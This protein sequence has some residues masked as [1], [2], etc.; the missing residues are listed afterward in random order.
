MVLNPGTEKAEGLNCSLMH[1]GGLD[2]GIVSRLYCL[3]QH[4]NSLMHL[5][6]C[7]ELH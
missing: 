3:E 4:E 5:E 1:T 7:I 6:Y 2:A